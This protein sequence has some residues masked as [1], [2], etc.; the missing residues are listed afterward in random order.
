MSA[1]AITMLCIILVAADDLVAD[2]P[3]KT[4]IIVGAALLGGGAILTVDAANNFCLG[5][6]PGRDVELVTGLAAFGTGAIL[7]IWGLVDRAKAKEGNSWIGNPKE[8]N[9]LIGVAPIE[10]G[11]AGQV[12]FRW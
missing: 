6:C 3:G 8:R 7:L 9:F 10:N 12:I 4:K 11:A 5:D 2:S 1:K